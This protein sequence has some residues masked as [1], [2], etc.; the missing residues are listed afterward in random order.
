MFQ[1][2]TAVPQSTWL[3]VAAQNGRFLCFSLP[4]VASALKASP[5]PHVRRIPSRLSLDALARLAGFPDG[6]RSQR[7]GDP[8]QEVLTRSLP[9]GRRRA[10]APP[11]PRGMAV[12]DV[13]R[14]PDWIGSTVERRHPTAAAEKTWFGWTPAPLVFRGTVH[15]IGCAVGSFGCQDRELCRVGELMQHVFLGCQLPNV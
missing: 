14:N 6:G 8:L 10:P 2:N 5:P 12:G 4:L 11:R 1:K 13:G 9:R 3:E 7:L 15:S